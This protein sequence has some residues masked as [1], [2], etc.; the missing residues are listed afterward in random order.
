MAAAMVFQ[1]EIQRTLIQMIY[2]SGIP[3]L[4]AHGWPSVLQHELHNAPQ[5]QNA[6]PN[7]H[8]LG[9]RQVPTGDNTRMAPAAG[10][11]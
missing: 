8:G 4:A 9:L 11:P 2:T 1:I 3:N 7:T 5:W 6:S 10:L